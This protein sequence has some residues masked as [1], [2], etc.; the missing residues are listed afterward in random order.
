[1]RRQ[2]SITANTAKY[3]AVC[4]GT[5]MLWENFLIF[6]FWF[7]AARVECWVGRRK[8]N[9]WNSSIYQRTEKTETNNKKCGWILFLKR[10]AE[11]RDWKNGRLTLSYL[12]PPPPTWISL[13]QQVATWVSSKFQQARKMVRWK[14]ED[15][16]SA[17]FISSFF[18][19]ND[20]VYHNKIAHCCTFSSSLLLPK[21]YIIL[22][23]VSLLSWMTTSENVVHIWGIM[24]NSTH[25]DLL[26][27]APS[28]QFEVFFLFIA[29]AE[30]AGSL[31]FIHEIPE[32]KKKKIFEIFENQSRRWTWSVRY[33][34]FPRML[35]FF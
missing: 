19:M 29:H 1:M 28:S 7:T 22:Y 23:V 16:K 15:S 10:L 32:N 21:F 34:I 20:F 30:T 24:W 35:R 4:P 2:L 5:F 3:L 31:F 8:K 11:C 27:S 14:I 6:F 9:L 25:V 26:F 13:Y 33:L 18:L 12:S 17:N